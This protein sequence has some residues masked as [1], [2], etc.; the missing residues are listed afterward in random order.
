MTIFGNDKM[1]CEKLS[2]FFVSENTKMTNGRCYFFLKN[3]LQKPH[4]MI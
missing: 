2:K 1:L 4:F 3:T